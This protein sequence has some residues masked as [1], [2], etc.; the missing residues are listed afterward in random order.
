MQRAEL[1]VLQYAIKQSSLEQIFNMF[2]TGQINVIIVI[3]NFLNTDHFYDHQ[4]KKMLANKLE[5]KVDSPP[6]IVA[7]N[8][9]TA[10][11]SNKDS[12]KELE[13][14]EV[15][16]DSHQVPPQFNAQKNV[17]NS[18]AQEKETI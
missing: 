8:A 17:L 10:I 18:P 16:V 1:D 15:V 12:F 3:N 4:V 7:K 2:A 6:L 5:I 11:K 14:M 13:S 9:P